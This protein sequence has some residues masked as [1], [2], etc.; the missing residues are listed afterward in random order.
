MYAEISIK[1]LL[2]S[3]NFFSV[4][5]FCIVMLSQKNGLIM[6]YVYVFKVEPT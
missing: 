6:Q 1:F 4:R 2:T 5:V 3:W